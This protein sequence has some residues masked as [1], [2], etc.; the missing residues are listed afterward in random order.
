MAKYHKA[1]RGPY[2]GALL[3]VLIS[4]VLA[5]WLQ[6]YKGKVLDSALAGAVGQTL[7]FALILLGLI[8]GE[9]A[10]FYLYRRL[11]ARF[12]TGCTKSLKR[13]IFDSVLRR[14]FTQFLDRA[15][16][17]Y[18]A[19]FT[20][21]AEVIEDRRFSLLPAL[22]EILFKVILV[23]GALFLL[24][25]R[26]ATLTLILLTTPLYVPKI[27]DKRLQ[28]AQAEHLAAVEA[29]LVS[30]NDWLGGFE[31]IKNFAIERRILVRFDRVNDEAMSKKLADQDLGALAQLITSLLSYLS[32]FLVLACAAWL[33]L[34]GRFSAGDFFV[35]IGMIDQ[36]S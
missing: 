24:D 3:S 7:S 29:C 23:A 17:E 15:Q 4:T 22:W 18:I 32:Y 35:A 27:I 11:S 31:V 25:W 13:D 10:L 21:E 34:T 14:D 8:L 19:K 9:V 26:I 20:Q 36:L 12:V 6:F 5:V 2:W 1:Q 16:G 30:V 33:V 28:K